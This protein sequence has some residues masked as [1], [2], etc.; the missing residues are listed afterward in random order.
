MGVEDSIHDKQR[1]NGKLYLAGVYSGCGNLRQVYA[2]LAR[3][4]RR[5]EP[6]KRWSKI[7]SEFMGFA[8]EAQAFAANRVDTCSKANTQCSLWATFW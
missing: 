3:F 5:A 4:M 6:G 7:S 1:P 2:G 8:M